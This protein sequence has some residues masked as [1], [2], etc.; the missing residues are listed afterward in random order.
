MCVEPGWA[1]TTLTDGVAPGGVGG[2]ELV[3]E[4]TVITEVGAGGADEDAVVNPVTDS[5]ADAQQLTSPHT[6]EGAILNVH[7]EALSRAR[8]LQHSHTWVSV[9]QVS[10][11]QILQS[12]QTVVSWCLVLLNLDQVCAVR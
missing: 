4:R 2:R 1:A 8:H 9:T 11:H 6:V 10:S 5:D 12:V 7:G 3:G